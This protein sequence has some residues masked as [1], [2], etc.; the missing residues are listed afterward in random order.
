MLTS[1]HYDSVVVVHARSSLIGTRFFFQN[2][3]MSIFL[4][5]DLFSKVSRKTSFQIY[6]LV[7]FSHMS[8]NLVEN[9]F[10]IFP[11]FGR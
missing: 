6:F 9:D 10:K 5:V 7:F 4:I 3:F 1:N 8:K 11:H 2:N